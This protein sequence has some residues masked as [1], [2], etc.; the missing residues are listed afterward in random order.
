MDFSQ[1]AAQIAAHLRVERA[2][3]FI[4]QQHTRLD[5]QRARQRH[6]L[7][8][9]AGKLR[10]KARLQSFQ[11][12]QRQQFADPF[13][14]A[15]IGPAFLAAANTQAEG[16]VLAHVHMPEQGVVLEHETH[17]PGLHA[18][19]RSIL[20]AQQHAAAIGLFQ[21]RNGAQQGG[22]AGPGRPQQGQ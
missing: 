21:S 9:A 15:R 2:E 17:A 16:D 18:Q 3:R 6:A 4:Q 11:L 7:A 10:R 1:P 19:L 12:H 14:D 13:A 22:L 20:A 5:R 8:L